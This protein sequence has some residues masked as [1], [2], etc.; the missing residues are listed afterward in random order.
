MV[1]SIDGVGED[2]PS[3]SR[4][5][6]KREQSRTF[7]SRVS[8]TPACSKACSASEEDIPDVSERTARI[9]SAE[10]GSRSLMVAQTPAPS[11]R[12]IGKEIN[13]NLSFIT[14]IVLVTLQRYLFSLPEC[15]NYPRSFFLHLPRAKGPVFAP[16]SRKK[17][18]PGA[19]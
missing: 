17:Q 5:R 13:N 9:S 6:V 14:S 7:A 2:S 10:T 1:A 18:L 4:R 11:D 3:R 19:K 8:D 15:G 16:G 12:A